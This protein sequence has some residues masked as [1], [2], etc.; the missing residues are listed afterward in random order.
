[1][2]SG[3]ADITATIAP[4]P[5]AAP[6]SP[7]ATQ[8][9]TPLGAMYF[10]GEGGGDGWVGTVL[11]DTF[12]L[13]RLLGRGSMGSVYEGA[14]LRLNKRVAVKVL[15]R[16]LAGNDEAL[17]RFRREADVTSQLGH[18]HIVQVF[19]FGIAPSGEPYLVMEYLE[20]EDLE[21]RLYR[22]DR[23]P[24]TTTVALI[25]Q[26][27]AALSTTHARGIV[28]RDLKPA[29]I[30]MLDIEGEPEPFVKVLD[31][32]IS[33][34]KTG[35]IRL[36]GDSEFMGTPSYVAPEQ[37][38]GLTDEID[39]LSD[40]WSVACIAYQLLA[41]RGPFVG[42]AWH[43]LLTKVIHHEPPPL[44]SLAPDV[45][46]DVERVIGRALSKQKGDRFPTISAFSRALA[47]A[48][49]APPPVVTT[50]TPPARA[51]A[52]SVARAPA[53]NPD[54][55]LHRP[56]PRV[57]GDRRPPGRPPGPGGPGNL[58]QGAAR[59]P[60]PPAAATDWSPTACAAELIPGASALAGQRHLDGAHGRALGH[61]RRGEAGEQPGEAGL[62]AAVAGEQPRPSDLPLRVDGQPQP[63]GL[64][65]RQ[66]TRRGQAPPAGTQPAQPAR[67]PTSRYRR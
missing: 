57:R 65:R 61:G 30:F 56:P 35:A 29:N 28:H 58:Q 15:A 32:G 47:T 16:E 1:M 55:R 63:H 9:L 22:V 14:Q 20:G 8:R 36:T 60:L 26:V 3:S 54:W 12:E 49:N 18:P 27:C 42:G 23:L 48:A 37:A 53:A 45:P 13:T 33:K 31:F 59:R 11:Q 50:R 41:G 34:V 66:R 39:H 62:E 52:P 25:R 51:P 24:L 19:D 21:H 67:S 46:I 44:S 4:K 40:Q 43:T 38:R 2:T 17:A 64:A 5:R 7:A 10:T 6:A